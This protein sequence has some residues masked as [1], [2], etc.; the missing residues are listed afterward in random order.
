MFLN[1]FASTPI[2]PVISYINCFLSTL[3][4]SKA[5]DSTALH[6]KKGYLTPTSQT[7]PVWVQFDKTIQLV[8]HK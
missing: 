5:S 8:K 6:P 3:V 4:V 1:G 2:K 7:K